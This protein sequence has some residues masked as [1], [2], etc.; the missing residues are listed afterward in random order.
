MADGDLL[1]EGGK[2]LSQG[3]IK[4]TDRRKFTSEGD[5]RDDVPEEA[6]PPAAKAPEAPAPRGEETPSEG[7]ERRSLDEPAGIDFAMLVSAMRTPALIYLGEIPH[8]ASR[9]SVL[10][11]EQARLQID[12]LDLLRVKT[13]G[14]LS[15]QEE[16]LLEQVLYEL[17][18]L[19]VARSGS[20]A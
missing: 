8:P 7:F 15:F 1:K 10:D 16:N 17:R 4:V 9:Q 3:T 19:Y 11:L 20:K 2:D 6:E 5:L 13:R 12:M 18:M 14:N